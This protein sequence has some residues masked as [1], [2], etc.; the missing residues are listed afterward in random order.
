MKLQA[1]WKAPRRKQTRP[2]HPLLILVPSIA[3]KDVFSLSL[4]K[5][6]EVWTTDIHILHSWIV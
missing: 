4:A 3:A 5:E 2:R 1:T 6:K